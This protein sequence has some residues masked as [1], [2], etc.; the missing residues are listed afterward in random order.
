MDHCELHELHLFVKVTKLLAFWL[1]FA[2]YA[3]MWDLHC[4]DGTKPYIQSK[5]YG[6][7]KLED[8]AVMAQILWSLFFLSC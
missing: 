3:L 6:H 5:G 1:E 8:L 2:T 4:R 7:V